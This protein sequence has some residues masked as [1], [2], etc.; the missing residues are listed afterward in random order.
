[1]PEV[2][3]HFS[4]STLKY[5]KEGERS[6]IQRSVDAAN[7]RR[8]SKLNRHIQRKDVE[9]DEPLTPKVTRRI[10]P[11]MAAGRGKQRKNRKEEYTV[12]AN[13]EQAHCWEAAENI[14]GHTIIA[15][16]PL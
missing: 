3:R 5:D 13:A 1:M 12:Q 9:K 7:R 8:Q 4:H 10:G 11:G 2:K 16:S 15:D 6:S 14:P